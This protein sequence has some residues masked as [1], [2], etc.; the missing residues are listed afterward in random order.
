M[1]KE[2]KEDQETSTYL[3]MYG[4][5]E[6]TRSAATGLKGPV[7][8]HQGSQPVEITKTNMGTK[9]GSGAVNPKEWEEQVILIHRIGLN[10]S[11]NQKFGSH[12]RCQPWAVNLPPRASEQ[13]R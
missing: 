8:G 4:Q 10:I 11:W 3:G 7:G 2:Q 12:H 5:S 13:H 1:E 6:Y 9:A